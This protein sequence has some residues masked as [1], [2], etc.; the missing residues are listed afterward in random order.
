MEDDT[1][2]Q[3]TGLDFPGRCIEP[4]LVYQQLNFSDLKMTNS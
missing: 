1:V 3:N 4:L 2:E